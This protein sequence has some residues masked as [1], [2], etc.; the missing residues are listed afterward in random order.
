MKSLNQNI[1]WEIKDLNSEL[2]KHREDRC[3]NMNF[4]GIGYPK[5]GSKK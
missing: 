1:A 5:N 2:A 4:S 3:G